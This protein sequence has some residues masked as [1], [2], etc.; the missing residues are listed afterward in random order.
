VEVRVRPTPAEVELEVRD[1]GKGIA[2]DFLPH[3]FER[4]RQE[5][6]S[7]TKTYRGLGLGLAIVER[8]VS[9]HEGTVAAHSAGEGQGSRF[10]VRLR[11]VN[12]PTLGALEIALSDV[13]LAGRKVLVVEDDDDARS[14]I[15]RL[16]EESG[17]A[18]REASGV[19]DAIRLVERDLPD[20]VVSD[21]GMAG[22][23]GYELVRRLRDREASRDLPA[24]ALTAFSRAE[25][26]ADAL[27]AGYDVHLPKPVDPER[28]LTAI[29]RLLG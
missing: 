21:I 9:L 10:V 18:V 8:L 13:P 22:A 17:A 26:R 25:D 7:T 16:L 29:V 15:R 19:E 2:S 5:D 4:F 14:M 12:E 11:R 1:T 27:R 24:V 3:I 6:A 20:L 23:D 28:L